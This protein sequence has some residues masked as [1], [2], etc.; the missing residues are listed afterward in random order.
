MILLPS[1]YKYLEFKN[2]RNTIQHPFIAFADI[3]LY[4][5]YKNEKVLNHEHLMSGYYL[6]CLDEKYSKKYNYLIN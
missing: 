5:L 2:I 3:E 1:R 4:M 6:H